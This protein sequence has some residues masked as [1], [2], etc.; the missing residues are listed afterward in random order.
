MEDDGGAV[1]DC[2]FA[3]PCGKPSPLFDGVEGAFHNASALLGLRVE[4]KRASTRSTFFL[5]EA[6][7]LDFC[8][9]TTRTGRRATDVEVHLV[10]SGQSLLNRSLV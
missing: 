7:S 1:G 4:G 9:P 3:V 2:Q 8:G 5:R 10:V 6:I